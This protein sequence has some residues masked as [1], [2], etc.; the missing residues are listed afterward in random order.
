M[1]GRVLHESSTELNAWIAGQGDTCVLSFSTGKD[2]IAAW[3]ELR[4]HFKRVVP[5][6]AFLIPGLS[7]VEKSLAYYERFFETPILRVPHPFLYRCLN[8]LVFQAPQNC[9]LIERADLANF[10]YADV[11]R[12]VKEDTGLPDSAWVATGVRAVDNPLRMIT[13]RQS[14]AYN[15]GLRTF[16][17]CFDWNKSRVLDEIKAAGVG[18]PV[19]YRVFGRSFDGLDYRFLAPLKEHFPED[20]ARV[21]ELFPLADLE[22]FRRGC[23]HGFS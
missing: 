7:F 16:M 15:P 2:S 21:L 4:R 20:Y 11:Y 12:F 3:L 5:F 6:Y 17:A 23:E 19:D 22:L 13:V 1:F 10:D 9:A 14:G 18:L 8:S